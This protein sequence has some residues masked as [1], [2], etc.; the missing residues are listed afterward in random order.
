MAEWLRAIGATNDGRCASW[1]AEHADRPVRL[2]QV[3]PATGR[4]G[5]GAFAEQ[6]RDPRAHRS[7]PDGRAFTD[8]LK[9]RI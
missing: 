9:R 1:R 8:S 6:A 4:P 3:P 2:G 7:A 5:I